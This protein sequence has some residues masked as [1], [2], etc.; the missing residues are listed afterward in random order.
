MHIIDNIFVIV[1]SLALVFLCVDMFI[2]QF[3]F[4]RLKS[5]VDVSFNNA[6]RYFANWTSRIKSLESKIHEFENDMR[7]LSHGCDS[8]CVIAEEE[9]T[10]KLF[11][12]NHE[13]MI[14]NSMEECDKLGKEREQAQK[15]VKHL[16]REVEEI[17]AYY[18]R[19]HSRIYDNH[20]KISER[21]SKLELQLE[22][23]TLEKE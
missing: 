21:L 12:F 1:V 23:M 14:V 22:L 4:R 10:F 8:R 6:N 7:A 20:I 13:G 15:R 17:R 19:L 11:P 9:K 5:R 16:E 3:K 18:H 2:N